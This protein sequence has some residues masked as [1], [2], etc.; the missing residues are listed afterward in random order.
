MKAGRSICCIFPFV[1]CL[2]LHVGITG[3]QFGVPR[4]GKEAK[5]EVNGDTQEIPP[6]AQVSEEI[7]SK[8]MAAN[9]ALDQQTA[10]DITELIESVK[11]DRETV[12]LIRRMKEGTAED[13]FKPFAEDM[14]S[15]QIVQGLAQA[16]EE[17]KMVDVLFKDPER[18]LL[19]MEKDGMIAKD[20]LKD[21]KKDPALLEEDTRKSLYF[22]FVSLA[23]AGGYV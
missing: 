9:E 13:A 2:L 23:V 12:L 17:L 1:I 18:A 3:A 4:Q 14:R 5:L 20:K 11:K 6:E 16:L 19:E 8:L 21:Y 15:D 10:V 7:V 22:M